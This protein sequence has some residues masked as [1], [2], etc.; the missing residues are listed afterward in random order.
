MK[1]E[2]YYR[3]SKGS[4][5][6]IPYVLFGIVAFLL[7]GF[8]FFAVNMRFQ[9]GAIFLK[10]F[11]TI[12]T[13]CL[14]IGGAITAISVLSIFA[15]SPIRMRTFMIGIALLWIGSWCTGAVINLFGTAIG[16]QQP[17]SGYH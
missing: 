7:V 11:D 10:I 13:F 15:R 9:L 14:T 6:M 8:P 1:N 3:I 4:R 5:S 16:Q 17:P 12:G 2:K